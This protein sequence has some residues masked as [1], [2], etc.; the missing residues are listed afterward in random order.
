MARSHVSTDA[1]NIAVTPGGQ[2]ALYTA[3]TTVMDHGD[4][5]VMLAPYYTTYPLMLRAVSA[6][7]RVVTC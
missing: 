4:A 2:F 5:V 7:A 3:L 1:Q 6:E